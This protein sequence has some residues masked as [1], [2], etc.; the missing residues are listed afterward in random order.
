M[1]YAGC[2][3]PLWAL[4]EEALATGLASV[5]WRLGYC[6]PCSM[7]VEEMAL[8]LGVKRPKETAPAVAPW[9]PSSSLQAV[10]ALCLV[11]CII[12]NLQ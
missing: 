2:P 4:V 6:S 9:I 1:G 5:F 10:L 3:S 8:G 12:P 7:Q 11:F